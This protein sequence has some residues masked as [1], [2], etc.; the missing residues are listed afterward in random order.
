MA[1]EAGID[2]Y[3]LPL[4]AG[5]HSV[6]L[7]GRLFEAGAARLG[8]RAP[9]DLYHSALEVCAPEGRFVVEQARPSAT[10]T[11]ARVASLPK[12]RSAAATP[13]AFGSSATRCA[14]GAAESFR[15]P[16]KLSR[17]R[18]DSP[19]IRT[20]HGESSTWL[21]TFRPPCGVA[22]SSR[23]ARC[24]TPTQ[25]SR[26]SLREAAC[27][28]TQSSCRGV[29]VLL[30]GTQAWSWP[31]ASTGFPQRS[32]AAAPRRPRRPGRRLGRTRGGIFVDTALV[33]HLVDL[34]RRGR[35]RVPHV[36][37]SELVG[38]VA[39]PGDRSRPQQAARATA[40]PDATGR[41]N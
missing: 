36:R 35:H 30:G 6:R 9:C 33:R 2:L 25:S 37:S 41:M 23:P 15:T 34:E 28:R 8:R 7:N 22:T 12:A 39:D 24:G 32:S 26:G 3:W 21:P 19:T 40:G 4:G 17:A 5:G 27:R 20:S 1:A 14:A 11:G 38:R 16:T 18:S 13:G 31:A 29:G 10:V